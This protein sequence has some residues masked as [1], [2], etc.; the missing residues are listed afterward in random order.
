M[1]LLKNA[2]DGAIRH[3]EDGNERPGLPRSGPGSQSISTFNSL[4]AE[5]GV[6]HRI[7]HKD[8]TCDV[9]R[10]EA[11]ALVMEIKV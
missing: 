9:R 6:Q 7:D 10:Q 5:L 1:R 8:L 2:W 4:L 11:K 3:P